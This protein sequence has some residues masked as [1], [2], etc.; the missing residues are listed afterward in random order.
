[1]RPAIRAARTPPA[2]SLRRFESAR[3]DEF[4]LQEA[5]ELV[6]L[7]RHPLLL[8]EDD[9]LREVLPP[10]VLVPDRPPDL[11]LRLPCARDPDPVRDRVESLSRLLEGDEAEVEA[12][13]LPVQRAEVQEGPA[14]SLTA[15]VRIEAG[16]AVEGLEEESLGAR[17]VPG[18]PREHSRPRQRPG[19][20]ERVAGR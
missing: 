10:A 2:E 9:G 6:R 3:L 7:L 8:V 18:A 16:E 13:R 15:L 4:P 19:E 1:A 20:D 11:G 14:G 12:A 5:A 17:G